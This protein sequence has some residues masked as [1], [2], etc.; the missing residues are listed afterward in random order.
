M[1]ST[2]RVLVADDHEAVRSGVVA[3]LATDPNIQIVAQAENGFD[4][5]AGCVKHAPHVALVDVR[6]PGTDGIWATERIAAECSTKVIVL[7]TY[8]SDDLIA[9]ALA[10]GAHGYLLKSTSG[11]E[12]I[13]AIH[14]VAAERHVIDPAIAGGVIAHATAAHRMADSAEG[15]SS[16]LDS[17]QLTLRERQV[18]ELLTTGITNQAI[19]ERLG[20]GVTTVKT[21]VG[22]LYAKTGA[23]SR[24]QLARIG[25]GS[26]ARGGFTART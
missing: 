18:L 24:V 25:E 6:M 16:T 8:D 12:L 10:A 3:I 21:H 4:A 5:L 17:S 2:V 14:H 13:Q 22:A 11:V 26:P 9:R 23:V 20:V 1:T 7:T 15:A 19:A